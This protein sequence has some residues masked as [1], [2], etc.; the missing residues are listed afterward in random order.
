[1]VNWKLGSE[2]VNG[3]TIDAADHFWNVGSKK[4]SESPKGNGTFND[5]N[6]FGEF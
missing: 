1:M 6:D 4:K 5:F 3:A 2:S